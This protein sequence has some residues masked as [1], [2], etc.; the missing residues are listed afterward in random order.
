MA[1]QL[2]EPKAGHNGYDKEKLNRFIS[3]IHTVHDELESI[4]GEKRVDIKNIYQEA[5]DE[6][7]IPKK[8]LKEIVGA[9]RQAQKLDGRMAEW[10]E[11]ERESLDQIKHL[12]GMISDLPLGEA[13]LAQAAAAGSA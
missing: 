12:L 9:Q 4:S 5:K 13:A 8:V 6:L 7:G 3:R 2:S 1:K 11:E 10:S